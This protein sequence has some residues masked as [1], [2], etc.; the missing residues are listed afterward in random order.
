MRTSQRCGA[1]ADPVDH[2]PPV[3]FGGTD[4][5]RNLEAL[6]ERCNLAKGS[7]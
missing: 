7:R 2:I 3:M 1:R 5:I 4:D 6:C